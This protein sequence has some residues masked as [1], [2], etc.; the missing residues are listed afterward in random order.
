MV[1]TSG[2]PETA[3]RFDVLDAL[4]GICAVLLVLFHFESNGY[5]ASLPVVQN[6]WMFVDYFFVLSGFVITHSYAARLS[7]GEVSVARFIGLRLGRIYPLH[8]FVLLGFVALELLLVVGGD[9]IA[10]YVTRSAFS[11]TRS[12]EALIQN[13]FLFQSF[14][15]GT[16][17]GWNLPA[18]S[19]A[20]E[21]WTYLVFAFVFV[22]ARKR[23][24]LVSGLLAGAAALALILTKSN[25]LVTF[26]GGFVRCVFGFGIGVVTYHAWRRLRPAGGSIQELGTLAITIGF[27]SLATGALTFLAPLVFAGMIFVLASQNGVVSRVLN[28]RVFQFLGMTSYSIYMI[29][30]FVQGRLGEVLQITEIV[31]IQVD[32]Q[33][34]TVLGAAPLVSDAVTLVMLALVVGAATIT[35]RLVEMPGQALS[36]RW[37]AV[38][39]PAARPETLA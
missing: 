17:R 37:L 4:R 6:G 1:N 2:S 32:P 39:P 28:A 25:L 20:A 14:G 7:G 11:G 16:A 33:G 30:S 3:M 23:V 8:L 34:V 29:H 5:I 18:W 9:V 13:L 24:V 12:I 31:A 10:P 38:Q 21:I 19:I 22:G 26:E 35:Y 27:V 36:R 15:I